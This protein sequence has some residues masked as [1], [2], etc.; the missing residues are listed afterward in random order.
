MK[1]VII[2]VAAFLALTF[3]ALYVMTDPSNYVDNPCPHAVQR[4]NNNENA[5]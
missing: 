5:G 2:I 1:N 3:T 4:D